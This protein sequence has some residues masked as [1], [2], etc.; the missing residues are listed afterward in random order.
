MATTNVN[1]GYRWCYGNFKSLNLESI[2]LERDPV[3][4]A[5]MREEN[6]VQSQG[7]GQTPAPQHGGVLY[8]GTLF[9]KRRSKV[10]DSRAARL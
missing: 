5:H 3:L 1:G 8:K 9:R 6:K 10:P 7:R 2:L 4:I